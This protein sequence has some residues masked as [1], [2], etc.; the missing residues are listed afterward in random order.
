MM[1]QSVEQALNNTIQ[2]ISSL[3]IACSDC[4]WAFLMEFAMYFRSNL[5]QKRLKGLVD[6]DFETGIFTGRKGARVGRPKS[7]TSKQKYMSITIDRTGYR[8]HRLAWLWMCGEWPGC[9]IDHIDGNGMNNKWSN[10]R[11]VTYVQ[12]MQNQRMYKNNT[13]GITGV[14]LCASKISSPYSAAITVNGRQIYLGCFK[15]LEQAA[16]VRRAAEK[17]YGFHPNHGNI[18]TE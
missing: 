10:L 14:Y 13:T 8:A 15:T 2:Q 3:A 11:A 7:E 9:T 1:L 12:N 6:Y 4:L 5:T 17:K 18:R 16:E